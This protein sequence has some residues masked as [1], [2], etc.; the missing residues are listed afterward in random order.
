VSDFKTFNELVS[1]ATWHVLEGLT[2]GTPLRSLIHDVLSLARSWQ[3]E[4]SKE[5]GNG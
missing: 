5:S 1:W 2:K 4:A 3:P